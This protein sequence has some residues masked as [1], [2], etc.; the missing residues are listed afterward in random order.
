MK[1]FVNG[2]EVDLGDFDTKSFYDRY[3]SKVVNPKWYTIITVY[4]EDSGSNPAG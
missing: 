1:T 3:A 2:I 4:A